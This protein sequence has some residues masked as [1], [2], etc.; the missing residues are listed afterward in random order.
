[1][2]LFLIYNGLFEATATR[3]SLG[4]KLF[5]LKVV[6]EDGR[7]LTFL[8]AMARNFGAL[9]SFML[10]G[11]PFLTLF[12]SEHKQTWYDRLAKTYTIRS[13]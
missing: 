6:D 12:L 5:N 3:G 1:A 8:K 10:Y 4:K 11:L 13:S 7:Q 9:L 2:V